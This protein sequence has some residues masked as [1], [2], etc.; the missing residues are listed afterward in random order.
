MSPFPAWAI[1]YF[2]MWCIGCYLEQDVTAIAAC[3]IC[4]EDKDV[5]VRIAAAD[6]LPVLSHIGEASVI[7]ALR[8][9]G[10]CHRRT[11]GNIVA[12]ARH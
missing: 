9:M 1:G 5:D 2:P 8:T 4:L 10:K 7:K 6:A 3:C 11:R 12:H